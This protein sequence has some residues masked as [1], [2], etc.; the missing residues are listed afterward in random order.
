MRDKT[1]IQRSCARRS[2][3]RHVSLVSL[4]AGENCV[5]PTKGRKAM[6]RVRRRASL[7][8][9]RGDQGSSLIWSGVTLVE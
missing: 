4:T 6:R 5:G 2:G 8:A 1:Q 3:V 9:A 7:S